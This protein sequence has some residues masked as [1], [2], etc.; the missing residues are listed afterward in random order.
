LSLIK[1]RIVSAFIAYSSK[2][3][4]FARSLA[5]DLED[6]NVRVWIDEAELLVGDSLIEKISTAIYEMDYLVVILSPN[7][8][9]SNWVQ[10]ELSMAMSHQIEIGRV[11][12]L[13]II[14]D[15]CSIP[16][17]LKDTLY[18]KMHTDADY[19]DNYPKLMKRLYASLKEEDYEEEKWFDLLGSSIDVIRRKMI[20]HL[21]KC[22]DSTGVLPLI[23]LVQNKEE[24]QEYRAYA[25]EALDKINDKRAILP[26]IK[27]LE[28]GEHRTFI[29]AEEI[30]FGCMITTALGN[31]HDDRAIEPLI[32]MLK[33]KK[34]KLEVRMSAASALGEFYNDIAL[35]ALIN[36]FKDKNEDLLLRQNAAISIGGIGSDP[37][38]EMLYQLLHKI[39]KGKD[40]PSLRDDIVEGLSRAGYLP[41]DE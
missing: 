14:A 35:N 37:A 1:L 12:V 10:K 25:I 3:K 41:D 17:F 8:V 22:R 11:K 9:S 23:K 6:D 20:T 18:L 19:S 39:K 7:S 21:G 40:E 24:K 27:I 26:L 29:K 33:S 36:I 5:K 30:M 34:E 13:P 32:K 31:F 4:K 16:L 28:S 15:E 2:D 38:V